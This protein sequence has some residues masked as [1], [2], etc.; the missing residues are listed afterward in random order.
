[1]SQL[2]I[3]QNSNPFSSLPVGALEYQFKN[4]DTHT[5]EYVFSFNAKTLN[6]FSQ[7]RPMDKGFIL[8]QDSAKAPDQKGDLAFFTDDP[9]AII[10]HCWFR[11]GW[12]DPMT[13]AFWPGTRVMRSWV[14]LY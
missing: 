2:W 13:I 1:M 5:H 9:A 14:A 11:G 6:D 12:F 10:D 4:T 3:S 8:S 7:V